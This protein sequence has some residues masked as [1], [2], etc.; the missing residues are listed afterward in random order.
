MAAKQYNTYFID[1]SAFMPESLTKLATICFWTSV[2]P[3]PSNGLAGEV[4]GTGLEDGVG[5]GFLNADWN[6]ENSEK[7][8]QDLTN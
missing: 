5:A 7:L 8:Q 2:S 4:C 3:A 6:F 1:H